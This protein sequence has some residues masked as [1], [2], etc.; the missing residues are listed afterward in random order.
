LGCLAVGAVYT[1]QSL[2]GAHPHHRVGLACNALVYSAH[3]LFA[4]TAYCFPAGCD[5]RATKVHSQGHRW[6]PRSCWSQQCKARVTRAHGTAC[7]ARTL[8]YEVR[9]VCTDVD[10]HAWR[11]RACWCVS[12]SRPMSRTPRRPRRLS[13]AGIEC[14]PCQ[15]PLGRS[16]LA[17]RLRRRAGCAPAMG[18]TL[19]WLVT[20]TQL[21]VA[22]YCSFNSWWMYTEGLNCLP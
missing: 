9:V 2:V 13:L 10:A 5:M 16:S 15:R 11:L 20:R 8:L 4:R 17:L 1:P 12:L 21:L 6:P 3:L 22:P 14:R 7:S 18:R 19:H